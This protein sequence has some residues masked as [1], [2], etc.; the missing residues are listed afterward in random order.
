MDDVL[1]ALGLTTRTVSTVELDGRPA[2]RVQVSRSYPTGAADLWDALTNPDRIPRWFLPI[3]GDLREG[4]HYQL[5]GNAGGTV[6]RCEPPRRLRV[7]WVY[8]EGF[9]TWLTVT[10]TA[11]A[12]GAATRLDLEHV[13]HVPE[14][15]WAQFG[16][17]ATGVGWDL[18]LNGLGWHIASGAATD[19]QEA[20]AWTASPEGV[21][22]IRRSNQAW[23][24]AAV[25]AGTPAEEAAA[26]AERTF[27]FYTGQP[28]PSQA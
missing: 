24:D 11:E 20:A 18:A 16:P 6:E 8:G 9:P 17:G 3:S 28:D 27:A 26:S 5:E 15:M 22:F 1:D 12:G 13:G 2:R 21:E 4:G 23:R 19:P 25:E 7:T 10:L 14:E